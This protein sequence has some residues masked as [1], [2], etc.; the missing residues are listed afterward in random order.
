[1]HHKAPFSAYTLRMKIISGRVVDGRI[2]P[3]ADLPTELSDGT[4]VS[5]VAA[6]EESFDLSPEEEALLIASMEEADRGELVPV[7]EVLHKLQSISHAT[8]CHPGVWHARR[9]PPSL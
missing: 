5:I 1:V 8:D 7:S 9:R 4:R 3:D 6:D 2:L